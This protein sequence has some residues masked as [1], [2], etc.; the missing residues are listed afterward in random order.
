[1]ATA[2]PVTQLD[3]GALGA[4]TT[5]AVAAAMTLDLSGDDVMLHINNT[6]STTALTVAVTLG[7]GP[8]ASGPAISWS[9]P[10]ST[11]K[12]IRMPDSSTIG[13]STATLALTGGTI[14]GTASALATAR[15]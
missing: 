3:R 7:T 12:W 5:A 14:A 11:D 8:A 1:M 10:A 13:G 9:I 15:P 4:M 6:N 2:I